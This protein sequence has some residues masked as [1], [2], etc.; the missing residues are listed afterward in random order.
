MNVSV[1]GFGG[2]EIGFENAEPAAVHRLLSSALDAGLNVI[3]TAECYNTSEELIGQSVGHRRKDYFLFSKCGHAYGFEQPDWDI[4]MLAQSIDRSLVRLRTDRLDL[5]QLHSC[6]EAFLKKGDVTGVLLRAKEAG[7]VRFIGYSGDN[8]AAQYAVAC[9]AFDVLQM[10][11]SIADQ[12][13]IDSI[14]P[15]A[16]RRGMGIIAKR[17]IA[18]AAWKEGRK[19]ANPYAHCYWDRL[20]KL[21]YDFL[22]RELSEAVSLAM[23]FTLGL[24]GVHTA[25]VGTKNPDRWAENVALLSGPLPPP[26]TAAIRARWKQVATS[27]WY[28]QI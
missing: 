6:S 28:G 25:I 7:K 22:Q 24:A 23:R 27:D 15:E 8:Q 14:L 4:G 20:Q 5:I 18:N 21:Q 26:E 1:L 2:A 17:P 11:I 10:S 9:G 3:D 16:Q 13:C 12:Q 19:P